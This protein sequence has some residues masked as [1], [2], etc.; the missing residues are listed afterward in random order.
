MR[1]G[2]SPRG[3]DT[4]TP[5]SPPA[6]GR[7]SRSSRGPRPRK[8]GP[9]GVRSFARRRSTP[10][11]R[12]ASP[13]SE[14]VPDGGRAGAHLR[15]KA[16]HPARRAV[17]ALVAAVPPAPCSLPCSPPH[18]WLRARPEPASRAELSQRPPHSKDRSASPVTPR[19]DPAT[20]DRR[21]SPRS[22]RPRPLLPS[23]KG[24]RPGVLVPAQSLG[25]VFPPPCSFER[26]EP[27]S[28]PPSSADDHTD[29][30]LCPL[31]RGE[32]HPVGPAQTVSPSRRT[33]A[34]L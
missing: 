7:S 31:S 19:S 1:S 16:T 33:E 24:P 9:A 30:S 34:G 12:G 25:G 26:N 3:R 4:S 21:P 27:P 14:T 10:G 5:G 28:S 20:L 13:L 29:P 6:L 15:E 32:P 18:L 8:P 22:V 23:R 11:R 17:P 2:S